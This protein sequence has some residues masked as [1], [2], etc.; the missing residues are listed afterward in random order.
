MWILIARHSPLRRSSLLELSQLEPRDVE[1]ALKQLLV[2]GRIKQDC[3]QEGKQAGQEQ[4]HEELYSSAECIIP[5]GQSAGWEASVFDHY[6]AVV[7]AI[8]AKLASGTTTAQRGEQIG[9]S[10]YSVEVWPGHPLFDEAVGLLQT[11]RDR[12]AALRARVDELNAT[13]KR[14]AEG[15]RRVVAYVGQ[16]V[17]EAPEPLENEG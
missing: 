13:L 9:G 15:V 14:P 10:T 8:C 6:Q 1:A 12:A 11:L 5:L 2:D 4:A 17:I 3:P 16:N 7:T